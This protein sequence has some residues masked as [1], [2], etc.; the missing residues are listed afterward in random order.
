[1]RMQPRNN[2]QPHARL[3]PSFLGMNVWMTSQLSVAL[4]HKIRGSFVCFAYFLTCYPRVLAQPGTGRRPVDWWKNYMPLPYCNV[5]VVTV[6]SGTCQIGHLCTLNTCVHWTIFHVPAH[7]HW[8]SMGGYLDTLN[9]CLPWT[10]NTKFVPV[11]HLTCLL[12]TLCTDLKLFTENEDKWDNKINCF[13]KWYFSNAEHVKFLTRWRK[14]GKDIVILQ[15]NDHVSLITLDFVSI[16]P[17]LR[18]LRTWIRWT[19]AYIEH[20]FISR[21]CSI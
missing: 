20:F 4:I 7:S 8:K 18:L 17:D 6:Y 13:V 19:P 11:P 10:L 5:P 14:W 16:S 15:W 3:P 2:T 1:M 12:W 9:T 21:E